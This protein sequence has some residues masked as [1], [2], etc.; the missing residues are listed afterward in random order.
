MLGL[1]GC[2][3]CEPKSKPKITDERI[4][5]L[6]RAVTVLK[7][8]QNKIIVT[9]EY[10]NMDCSRGSGFSCWQTY[11]AR[12]DTKEAIDAITDH[13]DMKLIA[14]EEKTIPGGVIL[15]KK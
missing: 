5:A 8:N 7:E 11:T 12:I 1:V 15:K 10:L 14:K 6:E 3:D 13:L 2:S 9:S 4:E